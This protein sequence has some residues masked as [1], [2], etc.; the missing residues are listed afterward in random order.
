MF[1][2]SDREA[3][4]SNADLT[5]LR[6]AIDA[7]AEILRASAILAKPAPAPPKAETAPN[8]K[9]PKQAPAKKPR[10]DEQ[11]A[12]KAMDWYVPHRCFGPNCAQL[13]NPYGRAKASQCA[14]P[15]KR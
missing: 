13:R 6:Q 9:R 11:D 5:P 3:E 1:A 10:L 2:N 15:L 7:P 14:W 4:L 12:F 8:S